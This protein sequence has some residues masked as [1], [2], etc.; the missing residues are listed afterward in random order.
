MT[1]DEFS[2]EMRLTRLNLDTAFEGSSPDRLDPW[3]QEIKGQVQQN[4]EVYHYSSEPSLW[5]LGMGSE[6]YVVVR[7]GQIVASIVQRMN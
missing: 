2:K 6:G 7:K 4:D 1:I 5:E 3:L